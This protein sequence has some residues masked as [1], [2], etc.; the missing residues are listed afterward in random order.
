MTP[1]YVAIVSGIFALATV[2]VQAK[3]HRD[4]RSDHADTARKVDAVLE[5]QGTMGADLGE[6]KADLRDVKADLRD[7]GA[8]LRAVESPAP[9]KPA[10]APR[11]RTA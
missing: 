8:R 4:N 6:M 5:A 11:K 7:H 1:V 9:A 3:V 10:R 2:I